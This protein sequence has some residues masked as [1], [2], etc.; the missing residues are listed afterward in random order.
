MDCIFCKIINKEIPSKIIY[1]DDIVIAMLD[2]NP[3]SKGHTLI[4]PKTHYEDYTK[5]PSEIL[6]HI[7]NVAQKIGNLIMTKLNQDGYSLI[8][9]FGTAQ[10][11]KHFHLHIIPKNQEKKADINDVFNSL[12]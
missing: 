10:E 1:E 2:I 3:Q 6:N 5:L 8:V 9:N 11:I 7:Y 4:V 12:K